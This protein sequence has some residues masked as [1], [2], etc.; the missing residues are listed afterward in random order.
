MKERDEVAVAADDHLQARMC[1]HGEALA[2]DVTKFDVGFVI[3]TSCDRALDRW[4]I[5]K[6]FN[7]RL[8]RSDIF[9]APLALRYLT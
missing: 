8:L 2:H 7:T 1:R 3:V 9:N 5:R 6:E 4:P